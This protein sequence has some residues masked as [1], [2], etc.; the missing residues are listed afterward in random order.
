M[1]PDRLASS[2]LI[3]V[4]GALLTVVIR[5]HGVRVAFTMP[6]VVAYLWV[7]IISLVSLL[8]SQVHATAAMPML[9]AVGIAVVAIVPY[10][11]VTLSG[12]GVTITSADTT[13]ARRV[14]L[15]S[16]VVV[17][18]VIVAIPILFTIMVALF[19]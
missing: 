17:V 16:I 8:Y 9:V 13:V 19:Y 15:R 6:Y 10:L 2:V 1:R 3:F 5:P 11:L 7:A 12:Y 18:A 4:V 14:S